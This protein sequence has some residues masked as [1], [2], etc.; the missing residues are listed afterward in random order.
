MT[1]T[2]GWS[3]RKAISYAAPEDGFAARTLIRAVERLSG[4]SRLVTLYERTRRAHR[5]GDDIFALAVEALDLDVRYDPQQLAAVPRRGPLVVVAN[6]PFG[7]IDG[8]V[9]CHLVAM[10]RTDFKIIAMSALCRLPEMRRFVLPINFAPTRE[11]I[12]EAAG[13]RAEA[14]ALVAAGG[15]VLVFPAGMVST[16]R[17][18]L[19]RAVDAPWHPFVGKL[20]RGTRASVLPIRFEGQNSRMFQIAGRIDPRIRLSLLMGEAVRR[21]GTVVRARIGEAI[22]FEELHHLHDPKALVDQLRERT[23][24]LGDDGP[25]TTAGAAG[26]A[27]DFPLRSASPITSAPSR[28]PPRSPAS[29]S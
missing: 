23:C 25:R 19:G 7:V 9:L 17:R 18:P 3:S 20:V 14:R 27:L 2:Q 4:Q 1:S 29:P 8:L 5:P 28:A 6:H 11:A 21:I 24:G 22:G 12:A 13:S 10:V 16:S 15:C 26:L